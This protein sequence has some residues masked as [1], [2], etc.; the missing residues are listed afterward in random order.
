MT[1]PHFS[2]EEPTHS[3]PQELSPRT[4]VT[5]QP[6]NE[7]KDSYKMFNRIAKRYDFLNRLLSLGLDYFWRKRLAHFAVERS[8]TNTSEGYHVLDL[9]T[10]TA[11]VALEL[12]KKKEVQHIIGLDLSHEMLQQAL[13]KISS[14]PQ[15][16]KMT[17]QWGDAVKIPFPNESFDLVTLSFGIRNFPDPQESLRNIFRVLRPGGKVLIMEFSLPQ[18]KI[19][20]KAY[21]F[22]LRSLLPHLGGLIS[23]DKKAYRY[24]NETIEDFPYGPQFLALMEQAGFQQNRNHLFTLGITSLYIGE[25]K[26]TPLH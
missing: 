14:H 25:K 6:W 4:S 24:L 20:K 13:Q 9:A 19:I 10:G 15:G 17:L 2:P 21:L 23:G 8:S 18:N 1:S 12:A 22:Y 11:D 3:A 16:K 5:K 7:K 26:P